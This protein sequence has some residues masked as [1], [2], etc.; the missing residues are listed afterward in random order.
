MF[1]V[2]LERSMKTSQTTTILMCLMLLLTSLAANAQNEAWTLEDCVS[3]ALS[4]NVDVRKSQNSTKSSEL[5]VEQFKANQLPSLTGSASTNYSWAKEALTESDNFGDRE[6]SNTTSFGLNSGVTVFN[7]FKLRNQIKQ[8]KLELLSSEYY[9]E[10]IQESL[11]LNILDAYLQILYAQEELNNAQEQITSTKEELALA[12]E[13][14]NVGIISQSDYLQIKSELA[15]EKLTLAN[16]KSTL[17]IAKLDLMQLMD[18]PVNQNFEIELPDVASMLNEEKNPIAN[19]IYAEAIKFKPQI[20]NASLTLESVKLDE[21]IAKAGLMPT[22]SFSAGLSS[23]WN[24]NI[25]GYTK[26][27]Q[28]KNQFTPSVGLSLSVPIFQNKEARINIQ[29]AQLS[30]SDAE[31]DQINTQNELRKNIEQACLDVMTAQSRYGASQEQYD[32]SK[33]SYEVAT[34]KYKEGLLNSVDFLSVKTDMITS[35]SAFTQ[36]RYNLVFSNKIL[37]F[38][39]GIPISL[40]K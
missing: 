9:S 16:A 12:E 39:K 11:E 5:N 14:L 28:L 27:N 38:Y 13:R 32:S 2:K 17:S 40:S 24:D 22:L 21:E 36:A 6:R 26:S 1:T 34:E 15:S 19:D 3:Y 25:S 10:T 30:I 8:S 35:E 29:Q 7:G 23:G 4:K 33:E 20:K 31:L 37:D 18:Y